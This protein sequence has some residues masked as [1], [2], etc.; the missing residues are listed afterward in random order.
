MALYDSYAVT[1][2]TRGYI[3]TLRKQGFPVLDA[4][5]S[6]FLGSPTIPTLQPE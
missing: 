4:L 1:T 6:V 2:P 5:R 3:S